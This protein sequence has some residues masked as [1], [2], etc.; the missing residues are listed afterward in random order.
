MNLHIIRAA[1]A[2]GACLLLMAPHV[3]LAQTAGTIAAEDKADNEVIVT[4]AKQNSTGIE[5]PNA[6]KARAV[7]TRDYIEHTVPGQ[8]IFNAMPSASR[9]AS[10]TAS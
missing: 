3:V 4:A 6:P 9:S 10:T 8:S 2:G 5:I 7:V 1:G